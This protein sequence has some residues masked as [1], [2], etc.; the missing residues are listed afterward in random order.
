MNKTLRRK[1]VVSQ[2]PVMQIDD[3]WWSKPVNSREKKI[4]KM[5]LFVVVK[6]ILSFVFGCW[7]LQKKEK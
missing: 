6:T 1:K 2:E 3:Q 4:I 7:P 5:N